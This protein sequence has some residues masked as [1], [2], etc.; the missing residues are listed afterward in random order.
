MDLRLGW[1]KG[2]GAPRTPV[3]P[4]GG[5]GPIFRDAAAVVVAAGRSAVAAA[6][7][8]AMM[9]MGGPGEQSRFN[10]EMF[11]QVNNLRTP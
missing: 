2:F 5:G 11:T 9:M 8:A 4:G 10:V 7:A 1:N 3:G 6:V